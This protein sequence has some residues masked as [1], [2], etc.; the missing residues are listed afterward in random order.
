MTVLAVVSLALCAGWIAGYAT[1]W[2]ER[3]E[4]RDVEEWLR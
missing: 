1:A 4:D 2:R 3:P